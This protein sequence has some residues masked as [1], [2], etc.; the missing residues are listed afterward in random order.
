MV[1]GLPGPS[2]LP[3]PEKKEQQ[4]QPKTARRVVVFFFLTRVYN[5]FSAPQGVRKQ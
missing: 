1:I 3:D 2:G 4:Q 5:K